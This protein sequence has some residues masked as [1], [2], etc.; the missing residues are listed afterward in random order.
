MDQKIEKIALDDIQSETK[1]TDKPL[2]GRD[3]DLV[4]HVNVD[5]SVL[6][7]TAKISIEKLFSMKP[8]EVIKLNESVDSPVTMIVDGKPVA[9]G[10][11]VAVDDNFGIQIEKVSS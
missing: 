8:G 6:I 11:L 7:G 4:G 10:S 3:M 9:Y 5:V 1:A 2:L